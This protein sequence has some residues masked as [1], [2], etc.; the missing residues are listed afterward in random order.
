M[1]H[2]YKYELGLAAQSFD[3]FNHSNDVAKHLKFFLTV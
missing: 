3:F 1:S 2:L